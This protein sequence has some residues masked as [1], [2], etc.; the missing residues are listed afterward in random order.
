M[1]LP[2]AAHTPSVHHLQ[3]LWWEK[4]PP[5][6]GSNAHLP[7]LPHALRP[8]LCI[9][10]LMES[11]GEMEEPHSQGSDGNP[12]AAQWRGLGTTGKAVLALVAKGD[13]QELPLLH[14]SIAEQ[15][16]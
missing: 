6:G 2:I 16:I 9:R 14:S 11:K 3:L 7:H 1:L 4:D 10:V 15:V 13:K 12:H 5:W 8:I